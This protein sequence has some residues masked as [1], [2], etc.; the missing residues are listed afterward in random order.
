MTICDER[1]DVDGERWDIAKLPIEEFWDAKT[2]GLTDT[3]LCTAD[4][5]V[6]MAD[7]N[8]FWKEL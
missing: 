6:W 3:I 4:S 5:S 7:I 8:G 2:F 1:S